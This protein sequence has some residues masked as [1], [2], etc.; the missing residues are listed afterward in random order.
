MFPSIVFPLELILVNL[1]L[2]FVGD[3]TTNFGVGFFFDVVAA[4]W[5]GGLV[6]L[7]LAP[8]LGSP[9]SWAATGVAES[10]CFTVFC[11]F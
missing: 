5:K 3:F 7:L 10:A 2:P 9:R 1:L 4:P 6:V 8:S 11:A